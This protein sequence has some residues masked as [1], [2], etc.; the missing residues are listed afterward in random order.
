MSDSEQRGRINALE[1]RLASLEAQIGYLSARTEKAQGKS[2]NLLERVA[3][4]E[5]R[6]ARLPNKEQVVKI[7][8]GVAAAVTAIITFQ[9]AIRKFLGFL[10]P[11]ADVRHS[12]ISSLDSMKSGRFGA[13]DLVAKSFHRD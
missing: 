2:E 8:L 4:L 12:I 9:G 7:A 13:A 5:E 3:R 6:L 1:V 11:P 10:A